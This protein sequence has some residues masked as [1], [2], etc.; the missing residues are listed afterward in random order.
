M[1]YRLGWLG[2]NASLL[3]VLELPGPLAPR[4]TIPNLPRDPRGVCAV[5]SPCSYLASRS[6]PAWTVRTSPSR[7]P[8]GPR[9]LG[10]SPGPSVAFPFGSPFRPFPAARGTRKISRRTCQSRRGKSLVGLH[11]RR[12]TAVRGAEIIWHI[13]ASTMQGQSG[14][15]VPSSVRAARQRRSASR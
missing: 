4:P 7:L 5:R 6:P 1:S 11:S 3:L 2:A 8:A 12:S 13:F 9:E 14:D 15:S 10:S